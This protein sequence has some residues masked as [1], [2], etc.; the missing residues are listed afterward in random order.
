MNQMER[1]NHL[2][3]GLALGGFGGGLTQQT[4]LYPSGTSAVVSAPISAKENNFN[5]NLL[6]L[7]DV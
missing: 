4:I 1:Y 3:G 2:R 7:E 5:P 6:L